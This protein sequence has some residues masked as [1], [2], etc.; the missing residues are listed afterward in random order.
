MFMAPFS[1]DIALTVNMK[2]TTRFVF[3]EKN[4]LVLSASECN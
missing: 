3:L 2:S 1:G 4:V